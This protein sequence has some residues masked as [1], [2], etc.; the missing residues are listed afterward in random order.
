MKKLIISMLIV[1]SLGFTGCMSA[2][3][4]QVQNNNIQY[5]FTRAKQSPDLQLIKII[6]STQSNLDIAI[7]SLTK[8]SIVD[9]IIKAK[10]RGVKVRIITDKMESKSKSEKKILI[11]LQG[12]PVKINSHS[13]LMHLK[14]TIADKNVVTTG[15]YNYTNNATR[16]ND[17][18]LVIIKDVNVAKDFENEF[19]GMWSNENDYINYN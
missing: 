14:V 12:I 10:N 16:V 2:A 13:G 17:E 6:N 18:V 3:A 9:S 1:S 4:K 8:Q 19:N 15:S 11:L 5:Y 7:Y